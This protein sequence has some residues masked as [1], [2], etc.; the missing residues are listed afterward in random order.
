MAISALGVTRPGA[1][2]PRGLNYQS[3]LLFHLRAA[4]LLLGHDPTEDVARAITGEDPTFSRASAGGQTRDALGYL[5]QWGQAVPRIEMYDIDGDGYFEEP[6][7]LLEGARTNLCLRSEDL[8][9]SPWVNVSTPIVTADDAEA[10]NRI[11]T[12]EKIEDDNGAVVEGRA[13]DSTVTDD[14]TAWCFSVFVKKAPAAAPVVELVLALTVGTPLTARLFVDPINGAS[15]AGGDVRDSGVIE[16]GTYYR[17]WL[18][19]DNNTTGNTN[20]RANL[21]PAARAT[22]DVASATEVVATT[23]SN[24]FWGAQVENAAFPSSYI[25]TGASSVARVADALT[26]T[27]PFLGQTIT[28]DLDD[29]TTYVRMARPLHADATG[30]L[31]VTPGVVALSGTVPRLQLFYV[32]ASRLISADIDTATTDGSATQSIPTGAVLEMSAQH[33]N[34]RS[35]GS[36]A[37]DVGSGLSAFSSPDASAFSAFGDTTTSIGA[38]GGLGDMFGAL[39]ELKVA[40]GLRTMKQMQEAF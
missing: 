15:I 33:R 16:Y 20:L 4:D 11:I 10:P 38:G 13:Q 25:R 28:E 30:A 29:L 26:Y 39:F 3:D 5:R 1:P 6:G 19:I 31:G 2:L 18:T 34:L 21:M 12:A 40:R 37:V 32:S 17:I 36:V 23:G 24:H 27:L 9:T 35:G 8:E 14:S 7:L 22:G